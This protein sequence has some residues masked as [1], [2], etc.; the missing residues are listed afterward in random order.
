MSKNPLLQFP[1][2]E[3]NQ[4]VWSK[5]PAI[6]ERARRFLTHTV[7]DTQ[8]DAEIIDR[9]SPDG[10]SQDEDILGLQ[11]IEWLIAQKEL[12]EGTVAEIVKWDAGWMLDPETD[13]TARAWLKWLAGLVRQHLGENAPPEPIGV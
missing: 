8:G 11:A 4:S 13:Q 7:A 10:F 5:N 12:P 9:L 1:E 3:L 6:L 2:V